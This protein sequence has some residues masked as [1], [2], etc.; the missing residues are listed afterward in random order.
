MSLNG[1]GGGTC[2]VT[3][4]VTLKTYLGNVF[5]GASLSFPVKENLST[6]VYDC[7]QTSHKEV[8]GMID[9]GQW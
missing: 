1:G 6:A 7:I 5:G 3:V 8:L 4:S 9:E 2:G